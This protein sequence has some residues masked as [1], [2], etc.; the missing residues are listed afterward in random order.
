MDRSTAYS[1]ESCYFPALHSITEQPNT[2]EIKSSQFLTTPFHLLVGRTAP[3]S[4]VRALHLF[5]TVIPPRRGSSSCSVPSGENQIKDKREGHDKQDT[6]P[7]SQISLLKFSFLPHL[8]PRVFLY[9]TLLDSEY[10]DWL[11]YPIP[12]ELGI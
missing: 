4:Q 3:A 2:S 12:I 7:E 11:F 1:V 6:A 9:P 8:A 5:F 10:R